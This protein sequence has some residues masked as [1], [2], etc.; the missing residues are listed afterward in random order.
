MKNPASAGAHG[1]A[2]GYSGKCERKLTAPSIQQVSR[3]K[4]GGKTPRAKG[5]RA[6]HLAHE[7]G[8]P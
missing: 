2:E 5:D 8:A 1:G 6:D 4:K 3:R 7:E